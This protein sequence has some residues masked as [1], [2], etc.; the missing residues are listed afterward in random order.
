[1]RRQSVPAMEQKMSLDLIVLPYQSVESSQQQNITSTRNDFNTPQI[2]AAQD[3]YP[4]TE[5]DGAGH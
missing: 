4:V 1:M 2:Q 5:D 3:S